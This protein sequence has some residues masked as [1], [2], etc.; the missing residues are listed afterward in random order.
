MMLTPPAIVGMIHPTTTTPL[1]FSLP[2]K[3]LPLAAA[4]LVVYSKMGAGMTNR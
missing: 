4:H 3:P 1:R 2:H